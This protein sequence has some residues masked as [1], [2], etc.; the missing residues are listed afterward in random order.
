MI[1]RRFAISSIPVRIGGGPQELTADSSQIRSPRLNVAF[2]T[3]FA[4]ESQ[5]DLFAK[6]GQLKRFPSIAASG[7]PETPL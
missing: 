2:G 3:A 1:C 5:D 4:T 7:I 6:L